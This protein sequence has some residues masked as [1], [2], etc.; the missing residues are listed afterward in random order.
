M[1]LLIKLAQTLI[2]QNSH[3]MDGNKIQ[4]FAFPS[5]VRTN[6]WAVCLLEEV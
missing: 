3:L 4:G 5:K 6:A 2:T 1:N